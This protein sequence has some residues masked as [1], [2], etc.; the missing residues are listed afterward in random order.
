M[1]AEQAQIGLFFTTIVCIVCAVLEGAHLLFLPVSPV[2]LGLLVVG[3]IASAILYLI[4]TGFR[5]REDRFGNQP[6]DLS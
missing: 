5:A 4:A 1:N 6:E 3:A 2:V